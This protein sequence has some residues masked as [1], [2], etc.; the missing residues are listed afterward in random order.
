MEA[1]IWPPMQIASWD[2][3]FILNSDSLILLEWFSF[4]SPF[5]PPRLI[6]AQVIPFDD[7]AR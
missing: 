1:H 3:T 4:F 7:D 2:I 6:R 5:L